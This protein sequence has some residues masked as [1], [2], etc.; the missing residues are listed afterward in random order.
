MATIKNLSIPSAKKN[1]EQV[2]FSYVAGRNAN[3]SAT[4]ENTLVFSFKVRH[5]LAYMNQQSCFYPT[6]SM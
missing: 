4:L 5:M 2:K 3:G 6:M 1:V